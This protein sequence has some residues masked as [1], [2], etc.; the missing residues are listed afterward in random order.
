[1]AAMTFR[2]LRDAGFDERQAEGISE[3]LKDIDVGA[4]R[5]TRRGMELARQD[6]REVELGMDA[7]FEGINGEIK[8]VKWMLGV[9][10]GGIIAL[11]MKTFFPA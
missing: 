11:L 9:I 3:A 4:D 6:I 1:M 5:A 10:A 7:K 8:A 2:K